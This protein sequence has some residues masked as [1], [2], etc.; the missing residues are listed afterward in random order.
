MV[1]G[2]SADSVS[3]VMR[4]FWRG[5]VV[6]IL[7]GQVAAAAEPCRDLGSCGSGTQHMSSGALDRHHQDRTEVCANEFVPASQVPAIDPAIPVPPLGPTIAVVALWPPTPAMT[8]SPARQDAEPFA[9]VPRFMT[10]GRL[11]R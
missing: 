4:F 10:F 2:T 8:V 5:L 11:L 9:P 3:P 1:K 6:F 7:F